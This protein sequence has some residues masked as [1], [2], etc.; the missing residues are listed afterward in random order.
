MSAPTYET[1]EMRGRGQH[2]ISL[3]AQGFKQCRKCDE[4]IKYEGKYCPRCGTKFSLKL[5]HKTLKETLAAVAAVVVTEQ[6][7]TCADCGS[8]KT[9]VRKLAGGRTQEHWYR[10]KDGRR[11]CNNCYNRMIKKR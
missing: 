6:P 4:M 8:T 11:L 3:M 10:G 1:R 2:L 7:K 9:Y 5:A